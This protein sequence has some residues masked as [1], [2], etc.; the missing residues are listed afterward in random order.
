MRILLLMPRVASGP[1][2]RPINLSVR[3]D[4]LEAA[5]ALEIPLSRTFEDALQSR[6][7]AENDRR[8]REENREWIAEYNAMIAE[9]GMFGD[10][11]RLF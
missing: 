2:R 3:A 6:V 9:H 10:D 5:R 1:A 11:V 7:R 4:L 8:W